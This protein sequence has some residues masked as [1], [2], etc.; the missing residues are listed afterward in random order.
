MANWNQALPVL[1]AAIAHPDA[2]RPLKLYGP[3]LAPDDLAVIPEVDLPAGLPVWKRAR[4][5]PFLEVA[6]WSSRSARTGVF[7]GRVRVQP[8]PHPSSR[9][10]P[11]P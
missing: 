9:Y 6:R 7:W 4:I 11:G 1:H 3:D 8:L 2:A 10:D 5:P